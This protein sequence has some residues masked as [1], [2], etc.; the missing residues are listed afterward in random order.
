MKTTVTT[1]STTIR[2]ETINYTNKHKLMY[3]D[4][5]VALSALHGDEL[6]YS[7]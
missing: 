2:K 6:P 7:L 3:D 1:I 4:S 5:S